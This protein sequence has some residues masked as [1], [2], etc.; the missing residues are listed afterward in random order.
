MK[1]LKLTVIGLVLAFALGNLTATHA[2]QVALTPSVS[3]ASVFENAS[4]RRQNYI[5]RYRTNAVKLIEALETAKAL[6]DEY[7][8]SALNDGI[9]DGDFA[10][11]SN[12]DLTAQQFKDA[13]G[14]VEAFRALFYANFYATNVYRLRR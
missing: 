11:S 5:T 2:P 6:K 10:N 4:I 1:N 14:N 8:G 9:V 3:A 7:D 13:A 12:D